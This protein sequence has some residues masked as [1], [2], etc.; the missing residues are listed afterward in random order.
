MNGL[1]VIYNLLKRKK[2]ISKKLK[3]IYKNII[4]VHHGEIF[5]L[6]CFIKIGKSLEFLMKNILFIAPH[7]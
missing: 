6:T 5:F 1:K 4:Q 2:K 3:I 7:P